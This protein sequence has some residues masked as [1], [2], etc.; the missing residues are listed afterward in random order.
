M[1]LLIALPAPSVQLAAIAGVLLVAPPVL[2]GNAPET[3]GVAEM[4]SSLSGGGVA[5][6]K[7]NE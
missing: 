5:T 1:S 2:N 4:H 6:V 7:L 3:I